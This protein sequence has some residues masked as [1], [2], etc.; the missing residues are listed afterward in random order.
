MNKPMPTDVGIGFN[1]I[2]SKKVTTERPRCRF[3]NGATACRPPL[4]PLH[5][6]V[7]MFECG[8]PPSNLRQQT[9]R[10]WAAA[11]MVAM[12]LDVFACV[13]MCS[14]IFNHIQPHSTTFNHIQPHPTT[15]KH[16]QTH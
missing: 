16:I 5:I 4:Q 6:I 3:A 9:G 1:S 8:T 13:P 14:A 10:L 12:W 11:A 7:V 2:Q 15:S